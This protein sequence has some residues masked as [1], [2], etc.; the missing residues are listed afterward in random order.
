MALMHIA[1]LSAEDSPQK[2][3]GLFHSEKH[4][5]KDYVEPRIPAVRLLKDC[6]PTV[7]GETE[8]AGSIWRYVLSGKLSGS[9]RY[10]A[11]RSIMLR[12]GVSHAVCVL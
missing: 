7:C 5:A 8:C 1:G 10:V 6:N 11:P 2:I 12:V 3:L 4:G 9:E